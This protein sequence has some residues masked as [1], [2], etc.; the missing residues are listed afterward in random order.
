LSITVGTVR[1]H[2]EHLRTKLGVVCQAELVVAARRSGLGYRSPPPN[3]PGHDDG[4]PVVE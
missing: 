3:E 1:G 4:R 2:L